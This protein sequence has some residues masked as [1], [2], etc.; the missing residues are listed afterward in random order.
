MVELGYSFRKDFRF[1]NGITYY[2]SVNDPFQDYRLSADTSLEF[3]LGK[4]PDWTLRTGVH[5]EYSSTPRQGIDSL[6]AT[7]YLNLG[8]SW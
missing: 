3:P 6:D 4:D 7:Y 5:H 1:K 2:P 8:Y